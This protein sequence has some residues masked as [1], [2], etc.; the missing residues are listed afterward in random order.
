MGR[1]KQ[2]LPVNGQ[3]LIRHVAGAVLASPA[4]PIV[5][6]TG[7]LAVSVR[8]ELARL[9]VLI[10]E[11]AGWEEGLASSIRTG[12]G[13]VES[14]SLSLD[15]ALLVLCDQPRI[16]AGAIIRLADACR[17]GTKSI[18][19]ARYDG[20]PGP[21]VLFKRKHFHELMELRGPAG[22]RPLFSRH[23]GALATVDLPEFA[24]DLDTP[25]DFAAFSQTA[26]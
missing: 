6:V 9:P 11:N 7:S 22:A 24:F 8:A 1:P 18:A 25:E 23:P 3:S 20:H 14:F 16:T 17:P 10:A 2:L 26:G 5:V 21:P 12:I 15:A 13:V 4:W 19:A